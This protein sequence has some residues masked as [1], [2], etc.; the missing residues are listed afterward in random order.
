MKDKFEFNQRCTANKNNNFYEV[1]Y[2][3]KHNINKDYD[4]SDNPWVNED[5]FNEKS[6][7]KEYFKERKLSIKR[8]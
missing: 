2:T 8:Q 4:I 3:I 1:G 7:I 6:I 5:D